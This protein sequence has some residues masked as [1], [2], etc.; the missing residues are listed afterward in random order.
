MDPVRVTGDRSPVGP[1]HQVP[2]ANGDSHSFPSRFALLYDTNNRQNA[3]SSERE[4]L[5]WG[6]GNLALVGFAPAMDTSAA[7]PMRLAVLASGSGTLLDAMATN[8]LPISLVMVDRHCAVEDVAARHGIDCIVIERTD[9]GDSF[10]RDGFTQ[11]VVAALAEHDIDLVAMAGWGTIL[12]PA[13]FAAMGHRIINT[14]PALLPAFPGWHA[15]RDALAYGVKVT[16]CTV[17]VATEIVDDGPILAQEAIPVLPDDD[18]ATL[19]ERIKAVER[20]LYTD[21]IRSLL[22]EGSHLLKDAP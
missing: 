2:V 5:G 15:V 1:E 14:H 13:A 11:R 21:T 22:D 18:E 9:F 3:T 17:H 7:P 10:D 16:G 19:H 6:S 12:G 8:G 4:R 20:R